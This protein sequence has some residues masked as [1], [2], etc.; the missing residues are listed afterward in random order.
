LKDS[1]QM[2]DFGNGGVQIFDHEV[3][4]ISANPR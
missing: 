4:V 3:V 2:D 1:Y